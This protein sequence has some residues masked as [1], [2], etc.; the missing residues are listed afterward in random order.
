MAPSP[1]LVDSLAPLT[2]EVAP[3]LTSC[4]VA[5]PWKVWRLGARLLAFRASA[6]LSDAFGSSDKWKRKQAELLPRLLEEVHGALESGWLRHE[7]AA[8]R[9]ASCDGTTSCERF[10]RAVVAA[11]SLLMDLVSE[12]RDRAVS[13]KMSELRQSRMARRLLLRQVCAHTPLLVHPARAV[14]VD[15]ERGGWRRWQLNPSEE[16]RVRCEARA[17][18]LAL[19]L[20]WVGGFTPHLQVEGIALHGDSQQ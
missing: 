18:G 17:E 4:I 6:L 1:S 9:A 16:K 12:V 20:S 7:R 13:W 8:L 2:R 10:V 3:L 15:G 11:L 14:A 19:L 5:N